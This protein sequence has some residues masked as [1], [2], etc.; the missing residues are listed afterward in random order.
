MRSPST[1]LAC[2]SWSLLAP[3]ASERSTR[4]HAT[5]RPS[6][7]G[8]GAK[9]D[10][11]L[12]SENVRW[13]PAEVQVREDLDLRLSAEW[14]HR[15][16]QATLELQTSDPAPRTKRPW[17]VDLQALKNPDTVGKL[18]EGLA[19]LLP[20]PAEWP[21]D[22]QLRYLVMAVRNTAKD[23]VGEAKP[24][25]RKLWITDE[26]WHYIKGAKARHRRATGERARA[27][28]RP[29]FEGW[30][31]ESRRAAHMSDDRMCD[32]AEAYKAAH[33][34]E[35][36]TRYD[37]EWR[38]KQLRHWMRWDRRVHAEKLVDEA[39][40][41]DDA[42]DSASLYRIVRRLTKYTPRGHDTLCW[43]DGSPIKDELDKQRRWR[44]YYAT[45]FLGKEAPATMEEHGPFAAGGPDVLDN[46]IPAPMLASDP[47]T[48]KQAWEE[49]AQSIGDRGARARQW[50]AQPQRLANIFARQCPHKALG[51]DA[52]SAVLYAAAPEETSDHF[53]LLFA[54]CAD[55]RR[56][57][58]AWRGADWCPSTRR[59]A[60][61]SA[62]GI[63]AFWL[64]TTSARL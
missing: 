15:V 47:Q 8:G 6:A 1:S 39:A 58:A 31:R 13:K 45:L 35:A 18:R 3:T 25:P 59:V 16:V 33:V 22:Q 34:R 30:R 32:F 64:R 51:P 4:S 62:K 19:L 26:T 61:P 27:S 41:A 10:Y 52:T 50:W 11:I 42:G 63:A 21:L 9:L 28:L 54:R 53:S 12:A 60:R 5:R 46:I 49:A 40:R 29:A 57:P 48:A 14:H 17:K 44:E 20:P 56:I 24:R 37:F 38:Q 36:W 55:A 43:E 7:K 23:V 2:S